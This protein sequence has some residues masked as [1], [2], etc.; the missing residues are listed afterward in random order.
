[1]D[2]FPRARLD[3]GICRRRNITHRV[4]CGDTI[5]TLISGLY[6][7]NREE[8]HLVAHET[9]FAFGRSG[10][11]LLEIVICTFSML[12]WREIKVD[13]SMSSLVTGFLAG[14]GTE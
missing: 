5:A 3:L 8:A 13:H 1:M 4:F 2:S 14:C 11:P 6:G 7:I 10:I 9:L 12:K